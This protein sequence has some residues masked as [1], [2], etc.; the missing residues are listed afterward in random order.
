MTKL[1]KALII[2]VSVMTVFSMS[3]IAVPSQVSAASAGDL[4]KIDG[5]APVYYLGDDNKRYV[6]PNESTY[7][8]WYSDFS[9]VV[10]LGQEEVESY[11]LAANVVVR[12]GTK[13]VK[14]PVPTDP[15]VYAVEPNGVLRHIPDEATAVALYGDNWAQRVVDVPDSFFVNYSISADEVS[16]DEYP[17][18]SLV[19]FG[20]EA[21]IYYINE[22]GE[23]QKIADEAA[24]LANRFNWDDVL[25]APSTVAM[26]AAGDDI[27]G[28]GAMADTAQGGNSGTGPVID[29]NVGS[30]LSVALSSETPASNSIPSLSTLVP[31]VTVNF[32]ASN[33]GDV[34]LNDLTFKRI[35]TGPTTDI[36]GGYLFSGADRL[37]N[38]KTINSSDHTLTFNSI[39]LDIPAGMTKSVTLKINSGGSGDTGN[40]AFELVSASSV[41]TNGGTVS[42][43][44]PIVGN[45]MSYASVDAATVTFTASNNSYSRDIGETNVIIGEFDMANDSQEDVNIYRIRLKNSGTAADGAVSNMSLELDGE[46]VMEGVSMVDDYVDFLLDNPFS[47]EKSK[48]ITAVVRGDVVADPAKTVILY[49]RN[50]ADVDVR[51]TAYG[52][53]YSAYSVITGFTSSDAD[54]IT[55][56]G[57][58]VN[59]SFDGPASSDVRDDRDDVVLANMKVSVAGDGVQID[60]F[61]LDLVMGS[62]EDAD[63]L[64]NIEM[65]D[66]TNNVTYTVA[67][68][69]DASAYATGIPLNFEDV[70]FAEGK[71]YTFEIRGDIPDGA[72]VGQTYQITWDVTDVSGDTYVTS[73]EAVADAAY[74]SATLSGKV[75][76]VANPTVTFA[77][78]GTNDATYVKDAQGVLLYKGKITASGV[79]D[80][81]VRK[82][83]L[84]ATIGGGSTYFDDDFNKLYFYYIDEND[85]E[86]ELDTET[87]LTDVAVVSFSGF[88]L[89]VPKGTSNGIYV[90]V[91]GDVKNSVTGGTISLAWD[92]GTATTTSFNVKD[93]DNNTFVAS[94]YSISNSAGHTTTVATEGSY[95]MVID[96]EETGINIDKNVL[97]GG[98]RLLGRLKVTAEKEDAIIEDLVLQATS[99][100]SSV[101]NDDLA[102]LY[103]YSDKEMTDLLGAADLA[104]GSNPKA[105]FEDVNIT[106]PVTGVT[107][108][109][110]G[111]LIKGIDYSS[112]PASDSTATAARNIE[113]TVPGDAATTYITKVI[114]ADTSETLT[115]TYSP[116][117]TKVSTVMGAVVTAIT[118]DFANGTLSNGIGKDIFSFKVTV[119]ESANTDY[120]GTALGIQLATSTFTIAT[121]SGVT[122]SS[123]KI[124]RVGGSD[125]EITASAS[126]SGTSLTIGI[127]DS[128]G[129]QTDRIVRPGET[130]EY[131]IRATV[132]GVDTND[133]LQVTLENMS[134]NMP[135]VHNYA[136]TGGT[137]AGVTSEVYPLISG[138]SSVRGGT[139]TN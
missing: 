46:I 102:T 54:V 117:V 13:L 62:D 81:T 63:L 21:D 121:T 34:T 42:G 70:V 43:A 31:F 103:L 127:R 112:S 138:L 17:A 97:A 75:M 65:V 36:G 123:Y 79:D 80:L 30:G 10:T 108:L 22:D 116:T 51:G 56:A 12:P 125:G 23:A 105:L 45:T 131:V 88:T 8:S 95:T 2:S 92:Y 69:T 135:Y 48:S 20:E 19:K 3:M 96:T 72:S 110:I 129:S 1:R 139:L 4:I 76:T 5:Y 33:D 119:P 14:R 68:P 40:H 32:T 130:A 122:L 77:K 6:F 113:L 53:F 41:V 28:A 29:P 35:G 126:L 71:D 128:Y 9:S 136:T 49:P 134:T 57:S 101:T 115:N 37:T 124:E 85:Q 114:G 87:S 100:S 39:G 82:V 94:Q 7:F 15:K 83:K 99:S 61:I 74:S 109:Y 137:L 93:S 111:G 67:D 91:R 120:D 47:L 59:I 64:D 27:T 89:N 66:T 44:F 55:I 50:V 98:V 133:S 132:S 86:V 78:Q 58:D 26:P 60:T 84:N 104:A 38:K 52:D 107:Y 24:F 90:T 16:A 11:P 118:T 18:G 25:N 106:V 73:D